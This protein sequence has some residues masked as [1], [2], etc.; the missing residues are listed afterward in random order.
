MTAIKIQNLRIIPWQQKDIIQK[1]VFG[2]EW[3]ITVKL[4]TPH[5]TGDKYA[6]GLD[7]ENTL[8][9]PN[10]PLCAG[11]ES[12]TLDG[13]E[14]TFH[15]K[16]GTA[17]M[18]DWCSKIRKPM[19]MFIQIVRIR[20]S[21]AE[22]L[23]LDSLL[24]LPSVFDGAVTVCEG[25]AIQIL[26]DAKMDKPAVEGTAGQILSLDENG[27]NVW[28]DEQEIPEQEQADWD[29]SDSTEVSYI[30]NK[31]DLSVYAEK[32]ELAA[33]ATSGDYDDL[34]NRPVLA[35]VATSGSY[36]DLTDKP[37]IPEQ[38]QA[39]WDES[40][41]TEVSYIQHKPDL[42]VYSL[43]TETGNK[44]S[45]SIDEDFDLVVRLL[46]K[47]DNVLSTQDIDLPLESMIVNASYANGVLTLTLQNGQ[48][49]DVD[50]S[51]IV[52]GLVP[53]SRTVNGHSLSSDV[54]ITAQDLS[55][56]TVA[57]T[58]SYNDL[59]DKP[60]IPA[61]QVQVDW[62]ESDSTEVSYIQNK[63][64]IPTSEQLVPSAT[65]SDEGKVLTVDSNGD[66]EWAE[67]QGG[68][69]ADDVD[70][71]YV[72]PNEYGD[73]TT[74]GGFRIDKT[75]A[76]T[77]DF[78]IEYSYDKVNWTK[79]TW[80]GQTGDAIGVNEAWKNATYL[81]GDNPSGTYNETTGG[82]KFVTATGSIGIRLRGGSLGTLVSKTGKLVV[83]DPNKKLSFDYL[84]DGFPGDGIPT[85]P[86]FHCGIT[87]NCT[88]RNN[89]GLQRARV[90][91]PQVKGSSGIY[92]G[93]FSSCAY[94]RYVEAD[95][96]YEQIS[97]NYYASSWLSNAGTS[98]SQNVFKPTLVWKVNTSYD[99]DLNGAY[100]YAPSSW[101]TVVVGALPSSLVPST[102][103][104]TN[105]YVLTKTANGAEW[106]EAQGGGAAPDG[107]DPL[108]VESETTSGGFAILYTAGWIGT[109]EYSYDK[110]DWHSIVLDG[111]QTT[112]YT[113]VPFNGHHRVYLR[114]NAPNT[115]TQAVY[116]YGQTITRAGGNLS[117]MNTSYNGTAIPYEFNSL[118]G[119]PTSSNSNLYDISELKVPLR[120]LGANAMSYLFRG[121]AK[122]S[123]TM[124]IPAAFSIAGTDTTNWTT[125][126]WTNAFQGCTQLV[127][128]CLTQAET[129]SI[130]DRN[131]GLYNIT[132]NTLNGVISVESGISY[133]R[134]NCTDIAPNG[135]FSATAVGLPT[136][137]NVQVRTSNTLNPGSPYVPHYTVGSGESRTLKLNDI[138]MDSISGGA[139]MVYGEAIIDCDANGTVSYNSTYFTTDS[140]PVVQGKRNWCVYRVIG[141]TAKMYVVDTQDL[142]S[143]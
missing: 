108:W 73:G 7:Y 54:T 90:R 52:S 143:A 14:L 124:P 80:T 17:R 34:S 78:D 93:M 106:A 57:T 6:I 29:E 91:I 32:S 22:T 3:S 56:A 138:L 97:Y 77:P 128:I 23:L 83:E 79:Y 48:T 123:E 142:P 69:G 131:A 20:N 28:R 85:L 66:A 109:I 125:G 76:S 95:I 55:L 50:I 102:T 36:N 84:F 129:V 126:S 11:T 74:L 13:D 59:I 30:Q 139:N 105:G 67:A 53:D 136:L 58:G 47:N 132:D 68:G 70:Y 120:T 133:M 37:V 96:G 71:L 45:M 140:D 72:I 86:E 111:T 134:V 35:A 92:D 119:H 40:D 137:Q 49:V 82:L 25:D 117:S 99:N 33:V 130:I 1:L 141:N 9:P 26:L 31:P 113:A 12:F 127:H 98:V 88:F 24:A 121:C 64:T 62:D 38:V 107:E 104:V 44:I 100:G 87:Y 61:A 42:S 122:L 115:S 81:R 118:F 43:V 94:L 101:N 41:S 110:A 103:S 60:V 65:S 51:D 8:Y 27:Q 114:K 4:P 112:L 21:K 18:R 116:I 10:R 39:D 135:K 5:Q 75:S 19:P 89:G 15:L 2:D 16:L 46:D 63:P